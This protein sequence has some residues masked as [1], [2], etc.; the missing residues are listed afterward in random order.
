MKNINPLLDIIIVNWNAGQQLFNCLESIRATKQDGLELGNVV[1][2]D[3]ASTDDSLDDLDSFSFPLTIIR[4]PDNR[5]F[6]VACNLGAAVCNARYLLF[7]NPDTKLFEDSLI[8]PLAFMEDEANQDVGICGIQLVDEVG[9]VA[10][11]CARFPSLWCFTAESLGLNKLPGLG[12]TGVHMREWDH[13]ETRIVDHV[14]GAFFLVRRN[15]FEALKGFDER[16]FVYLEDIDFSFRA[17]KNGWKSIFLT[18]SSAYHAGGGTSRQIKD[19]RLF[20]S[21]RSRLL[22]GLKHFPIWQ[23]WVLFGLTLFVEPLTR[24]VFSLFRGEINDVRNTW[25]GYSMLYGDL[26]NILGKPDENT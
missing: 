6:G 5:G 12:S 3:N 21:L 24:S 8:V 1:V 7:L 17:K 4:N 18:N 23:T 22:Y 25:K 2:V 16:Y 10:R 15:V 19:V 9:E 14:I 26:P 20:Y 11:S 13:S